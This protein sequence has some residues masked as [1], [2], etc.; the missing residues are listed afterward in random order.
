[1]ADDTELPCAR[2]G[3]EDTSF[4][5]DTPLTLRI[6]QNCKSVWFRS[7]QREQ[8]MAAIKNFLECN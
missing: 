7:K 4:I 3:K 8:V 1:M 6:C 2:C 5:V